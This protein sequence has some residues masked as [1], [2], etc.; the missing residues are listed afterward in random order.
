MSVEYF[1]DTNVL[2]YAAT[3]H[4]ADEWKRQKA[5]SL[6]EPANFATSGQ[7]LQEFFV[8]VTSKVKAKMS[9]TDAAE[10]IDRIATCPVVPVDAALVKSAVLLAV[11]YRIS[12][13]DAAVIAAAERAAAPTLYSE[14]LN[15]G[16][17]YGSVRVLNPFRE[18]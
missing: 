6:M 9:G 3:G 7:V 8:A 18:H 2:V 11:R 5:L 4:D 15:H 14:D 13:W 16:Q 10:W 12:Q 17:T 1:I